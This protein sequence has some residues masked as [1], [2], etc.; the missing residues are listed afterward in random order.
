M[1]DSSYYLVQCTTI[2]R[3][4]IENRAVNGNIEREPTATA[5]ETLETL[6]GSGAVCGDGTRNVQFKRHMR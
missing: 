5:L 2:S 6:C 3:S 4:T 1:T